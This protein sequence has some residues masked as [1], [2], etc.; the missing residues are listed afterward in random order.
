MNVLGIFAKY[1]Q[2][3][4]VKT[5]LARDV[6]AEAAA[7]L[8]RAF[9]ETLLARFR[10]AGECRWLACTPDDSLP[11]FG[12]LAEAAWVC[13]PQGGG[14]L[15]QRMARFFDR[16]FAAGAQRV[17]LI[18]SDSPDLPVPIVGEAFERLD[19]VPVVLGPA[20]DGGYYLVGARGA[21]PP[22]FDQVAWSS[23]AVWPQTLF[24]L[25]EHGL[26]WQE[27]SPWR[28]I[29]TLA[30]L[31]RVHTDLAAADAADGALR[32][33]REAITCELAAAPPLP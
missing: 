5:R 26:A 21:T 27:L 17:V 30:D 2:P 1:W 19:E 23:P 25:R 28:D 29:D 31:L 24:R 14:D 3:G 4:E 22:L 13:V 33:L 11:A 18:G 16:A 8:H 7:R 9:V 12:E 10:D 15:G 32:R 6:G 20:E